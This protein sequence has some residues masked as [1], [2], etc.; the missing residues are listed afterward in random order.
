MEPYRDIALAPLSEA[1]QRP[2]SFTTSQTSYSHDVTDALKDEE[3]EDLLRPQQRPEKPHIAKTVLIQM[4]AFLWLVPILAL[5]ILN[6]KRH[7]IGASAWCPLGHCLPHVNVLYNDQIEP[8]A[9]AATHERQSR[10]LLGALQFVSKA[11]EIW[12][13]LIATWLVYLAT[14]FVASK[15]GGLPVGYLS[16]PSEFAE[17][18]MAVLVLPTL[19]WIDTD[20]YGSTKLG[21]VTSA[22]PPAMT[23]RLLSDSGC[24]THPEG[25][26]EY[27]CASKWATSLDGWINEYFAT[28]AAD[29]AVSVQDI[30]SFS[31]NITGL[32]VTD[33]LVEVVTWA[34]SRR[35]I[36][37][38]SDDLRMVT[39]IS[40]GLVL[41]PAERTNITARKLY[42][43]YLALNNTMQTSIYRN[44]PV[45]GTIANTWVGYDNNQNGTIPVGVG[46]EI[47]CYTGYNLSNMPMCWAEKCSDDV[48]EGNYTRCISVGDGWSGYR[49]ASFGIDHYWKED[50]GIF[51]PY[52]NFTIHMSPLVA[53]LPE[54]RPPD[55]V[56]SGCLDST[57]DPDECDWD[58]FFKISDDANTRYRSRNVTT[59]ELTSN[60]R[61]TTDQHPNFTSVTID[62]TVYQALANY[63]LDPSYITNPLFT[64]DFQ[65][66]GLGEHSTMTDLRQVYI[67]P[68]WSL[69][70]WSATA[71]EN[72]VATR[73]RGMNVLQTFTNLF[74]T[75]SYHS[76]IQPRRNGTIWMRSG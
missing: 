53:L 67:D 45:L 75:D 44:G 26:G 46:K 68:A 50:V 10:N 73:S 49:N 65:L 14:M 62:F 16:R 30:I 18:P 7:I 37:D 56:V 36:Q 76:I 55:G 42:D 41:D 63:T 1:H 27:S 61:D 72:L 9:L 8:K 51:S 21:E 25:P 33:T 28:Q 47:K 24:S 43:S 38:L 13:I 22:E 31:Y 54:G 23:G 3:E 74:D 5:L 69:A 12:F 70:A 19:Q 15:Q 4:F 52:V 6:I 40:N 64:A 11:L 71:G 60:P 48:P 20:K 29:S 66:A 34:P 39:G 57:V 59:W 58:I 2:T 35:I 32:P 17:V